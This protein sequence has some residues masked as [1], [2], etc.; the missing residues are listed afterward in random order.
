LGRTATE[1]WKLLAPILTVRFRGHPNV[2]ATNRMTLEVTREDFLTVRGDCI[3]GIE[4]D[5]ACK[6]LNDDARAAICSD[7]TRLKF[8][9]EVEGKSFEFGACG[10]SLLTLTHPLSMVIRRS[11]YCCSRT[12]AVKSTAAALDVPRPMVAMLSSGSSG[13]LKAY[14]IPS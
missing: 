12:L 7:S 8:V 2:R 3:L 9:I 10:S 6:D 4:A 5:S 13:E 14:L 11:T 1:G